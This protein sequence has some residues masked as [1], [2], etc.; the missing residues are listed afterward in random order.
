MKLQLK[1]RTV[2]GLFQGTGDVVICDIASKEMMNLKNRC[3]ITIRLVQG[4]SLGIHCHKQESEIYFI[5]QGRGWYND[6]GKEYEIRAGEAVICF[7]G[8]SHGICNKKE[9]ELIFIA[10]VINV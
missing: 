3:F 1:E 8:D 10:L 5:I 7:D 2:R 4:A 6:N 9:E